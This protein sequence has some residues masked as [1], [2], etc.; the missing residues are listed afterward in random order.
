MCHQVLQYMRLLAPQ[1][2]LDSAPNIN[3]LW[4][5][6]LVEE[7]CRLGVNTFAI[8]PGSR[9]SPL[10]AAIAA[11]SAAHVVCGI[12]E[13]SLAFWALGHSKATG[14]PAVVVCSS[15]TAVA[16]LMPAVVEACQSN[17]PLLLLT[18]DRPFELVDTGS[19]QTIDQAKI[20]GGYVRWHAD[21]DAPGGAG[22]PAR[23]ALTTM[24][25]AVRAAT[26]GAAAGSRPGPVHINCR[27]RDPLVPN[28]H[29]W[30][31][32]VLK[33]WI[34]VAYMFLCGGFPLH[35]P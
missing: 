26:G 14:R 35:L 19:N 17:T 12:D 27:Y 20:F 29:D 34:V 11:Q 6:L 18:A 24:D 13:R 28:V 22:V 8:A 21:L 15:G 1:P 10:T 7:A 4:A 3:A 23:V 33:V 32:A 30:D 9:S 25:A 5:R 16:N 2:P 31:R